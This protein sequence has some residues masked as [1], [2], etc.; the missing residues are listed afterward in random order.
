M[1]VGWGP[2]GH[3]GARSPVAKFPYCEAA[4][5]LPWME[6]RKNEACPVFT[7]ASSDQRPTWLN[8]PGESDESGQINAFFRWKSVKD[9]PTVFAMRL[10]LEGAASDK[11]PPN[12]PKESVADITLRRLQKFQVVADKSYEWELVRE[13]KSLASGVISPDP[14][15]LLTI[16]KATITVTPVELRV[17][18]R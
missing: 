1:V 2:F 8:K 4:L 18:P 3:T 6:I 15:G 14:A 11:T 9:T 7:H 10:W 13:G 5:A 17:R 12:A 16:P